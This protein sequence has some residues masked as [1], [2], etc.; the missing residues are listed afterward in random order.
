MLDEG[1]EAC[2]SWG[3]MS[4]VGAADAGRLEGILA[5]DEEAAGGACPTFS[6]INSSEWMNEY[7]TRSL[8]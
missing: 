8:S 4:S 3:W 2:D 1:P 6:C 5:A 7:A